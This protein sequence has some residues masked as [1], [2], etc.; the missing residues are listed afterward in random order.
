MIC[1]IEGDRI[2]CVVDRVNTVYKA[3][4]LENRAFLGLVEKPRRGRP[5]KVVEEVIE[6]GDE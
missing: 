6:E 5:P 3:N 4:T 1:T 2:K